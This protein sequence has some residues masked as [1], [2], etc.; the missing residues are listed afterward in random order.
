MKKYL[1]LFILIILFVLSIGCVNASDNLLN[2][3]ND[4]I[5]VSGDGNDLNNGL[6]QN[7]SFKTIDKALNVGNLIK[8][9]ILVKGITLGN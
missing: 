7:S 3:I 6:T 2:D 8:L 4:T 1:K 9:F 5:Y